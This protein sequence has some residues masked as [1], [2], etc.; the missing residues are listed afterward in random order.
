M[1]EF[2]TFSRHDKMIIYLYL[3]S[4]NILSLLFVDIWNCCHLMLDKFIDEMNIDQKDV[5]LLD[6]I[7]NLSDK[8]SR[9]TVLGLTFILLLPS[10]YI[11]KDVVDSSEYCEGNTQGSACSETGSIAEGKSKYTNDKE[12]IKKS[13]SDFKQINLTQ[14]KAYEVLLIWQ[15]YD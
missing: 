2:D 11:T 14:R 6:V 1:V 12:I 4:C 8:M 9:S 3:F 13:D 7:L 10:S 5:W 15:T